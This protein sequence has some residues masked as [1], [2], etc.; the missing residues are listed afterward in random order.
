MAERED[1]PRIG[2]FSI[3]VPP[4]S[5]NGHHTS[6]ES[7]LE[8]IRR[9]APGLVIGLILSVSTV[10]R[11]ALLRTAEFAY[12]WRIVIAA[13]LGGVLGGVAQRG[14]AMLAALTGGLI[15]VA[16]LLLAYTIV[17]GEV[18]Q[19]VS[20]GIVFADAGRLVAWGLIVGGT[21]ALAGS[22]AKRLVSRRRARSD[23]TD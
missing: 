4:P 5:P 17:R 13:G 21:F 8:P 7:A 19:H 6:K 11:A 10:P 20:A 9:A 2:Q 23:L 16:G 22:G 15:A 3:Q 18:I 12:W 1:Q 14:S